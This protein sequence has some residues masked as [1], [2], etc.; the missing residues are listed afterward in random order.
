MLV[1]LTR[2]LERRKRTPE[3]S[4][5]QKSHVQSKTVAG[6]QSPQPLKQFQILC[7]P[8]TNLVFFR[9]YSEV[10]VED[11]RVYSGQ[12]NY[13]GR[14]WTLVSNLFFKVDFLLFFVLPS[15]VMQNCS[16]EEL[17]FL[18]LREITVVPALTDEWHFDHKLS[19]FTFRIPGEHRRVIPS[20]SEV[21][22]KRRDAQVWRFRALHSPFDGCFW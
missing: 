16:Q 10:T 11:L 19:E 12:R 8:L 15:A 5:L 6:K 18:N 17:N 22:E 21:H 3:I 14:S 1:H 20:R 2:C 7:M 13:G 9:R 4:R